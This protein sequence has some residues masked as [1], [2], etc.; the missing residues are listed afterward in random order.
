MHMLLVNL[1]YFPFFRCI[2]RVGTIMNPVKM[3]CVC[4]LKVGHTPAM[5]NIAG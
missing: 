3:L 5:P 1:S 4:F 2:V